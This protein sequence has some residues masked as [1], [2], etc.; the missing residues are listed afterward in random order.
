V[1]KSI[2]Q[3]HVTNVARGFHHV[4]RLQIGGGQL[5]NQTVRKAEAVDF[6]RLPRTPNSPTSRIEQAASSNL[7]NAS[8]LRRPIRP[9]Q[10]L[11]LR[12]LNANLTLEDFAQ[13]IS[14]GTAYYQKVIPNRDPHTLKRDGDYFLVFNNAVHLQQ[15]RVRIQELWREAHAYNQ[16]R[17][18]NSI[19]PGVMPE[20]SLL[21]P[22]Q[23]VRQ[24]TLLPPGALL[25]SNVFD[26]FSDYHNKLIQQGGYDLIVDRHDPS[27]TKVLLHVIGI[28][29]KLQDIVQALLSD[30]IRRNRT[31]NVNLT[32]K[33][34][35]SY[36]IKNLEEEASIGL[37][38]PKSHAD[39][40]RKF[41]DG[42]RWIIEFKTEDSAQRFA[43]E[44]HAR[45]FML[46]TQKEYSWQLS[47]DAQKSLRVVH[48]SDG[49][50]HT[51]VY[52]EVLW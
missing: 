17:E 14:D 22:P 52:T 5:E 40:A 7:S 44:W 41:Q 42:Q 2:V 37:E 30:S 28:K 16:T 32:K 15:W 26:S 8:R 45:P 18:S 39:I 23:Q 48:G 35:G 46:P 29:L 36:R 20:D 4:R 43:R 21:A 13:T 49:F 11:L 6:Q 33:S 38:R 25:K 27:A 24:F 51:K 31:W 3:H 47:E 50:A 34:D 19:N 9:E 10:V 1:A 12:S